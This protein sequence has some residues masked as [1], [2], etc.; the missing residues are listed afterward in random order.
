M[1]IDQSSLSVIE[2]PTARHRFKEKRGRQILQVMWH[3]KMY[4]SG[5]PHKEHGE[6]RDVEC[7]GA[8]APDV[9]ALR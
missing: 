2:T 5:V 4:D 6:W 1:S 9:E 3:V 8:D 7:V